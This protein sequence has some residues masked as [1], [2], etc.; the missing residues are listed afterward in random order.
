[1][2]VCVCVCVC[3]SVCLC[4][5]HAW[6]C[7]YVCACVCGVCVCVC[8][9]VCVHHMQYFLSWGL[10]FWQLFCFLATV[11]RMLDCGWCTTKNIRPATKTQ[12][13]SHASCSTAGHHQGLGAFKNVVNREKVKRWCQPAARGGWE[14]SVFMK[15][16]EV[17]GAG[18][19]RAASTPGLKGR[20]GNK[21]LRNIR[22][23]GQRR[24]PE[25]A[26]LVLGGEDLGCD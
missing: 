11:W 5:S 8:L 24:R 16:I 7:V 23:A 10:S 13:R 6:V 25:K 21:G 17:P 22:T 9:C 20:R 4:T 3:V 19:C 26:A 18:N 12:G 14:S 1:M 15:N 2:R